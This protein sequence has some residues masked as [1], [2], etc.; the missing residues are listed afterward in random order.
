MKTNDE[1][2]SIQKEW[3]N[4]LYR[5][6][7][8][9]Y[10]KN[11]TDK[12]SC[13]FSF[14]VSERYL[15]SDKKIMIVGQEANGHSYDYAEWGIENE[16]GLKKFQNWA[17]DY[18]DFQ[19][20]NENQ[21]NRNFKINHSPFWKFCRDLAKEFGVCWNN[22]DKVRRYTRQDGVA[23]VEDYLLETRDSNKQKDRSI[24]HRKIFGGKSLLQK[25]IEIAK[26]DAVVF[27]IGPSWPYYHSLSLAFFDG[28]AVDKE[29]NDCGVKYPDMK[30]GYYC[31]EIG[32]F[33]R[34]DIPAYYTYHPNYLLR[35][36]CL[37]KVID[38]ICNLQKN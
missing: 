37:D 36:N 3:Q 28:A 15:N 30:S 4:K 21:N 12:L 32:E 17:V 26:P 1:L 29:L 18:L 22:I 33:L 16:N 31:V 19:V 11:E 35:K 7:F 6:V 34:L 2:L 13:A 20:Y 9:N 27:A 10:K 38:R 5:E 23:F 8:D 14:G 25:E 24:L